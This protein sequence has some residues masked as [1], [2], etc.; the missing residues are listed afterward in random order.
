MALACA[1]KVPRKGGWQAA[2]WWLFA[3]MGFTGVFAYQ[4]LENWDIPIFTSS[5]SAEWWSRFLRVV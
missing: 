4:F 1:A 5:D 3:A 2:P